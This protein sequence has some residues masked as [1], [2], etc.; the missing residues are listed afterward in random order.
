ME[1]I[2]CFEQN[3]LTCS[4]C[5]NSVCIECVISWMKEKAE[6]VCP[7]CN[8]SYELSWIYSKTSISQFVSFNNVLKECL[9]LKEQRHFEATKPFV[10]VYEKLT[11]ANSELFHL[12]SKMEFVKC[13]L[14]E[15]VHAKYPMYKHM[16][17]LTIMSLLKN[18]F[19]YLNNDIEK[20]NRIYYSGILPTDMQESCMKPII[21]CFKPNCKGVIHT[22]YYC[23]ICKL[24]I[25]IHCH[26]EMSA[27]HVC[28]N[29]L[30]ETVQNI[31]ETTKPCPTCFTRIMKTDGCDQMFCIDCKT[32]FSWDTGKIEKGRI[33]N[34]HYYQLVREGKIIPTQYE[35]TGREPQIRTVL[36]FQFARIYMHRQNVAFYEMIQLLEYFNHVYHEYLRCF[37]HNRM[38]Q[39]IENEEPFNL[40]YSTRVQYLQNFCT[41]EIFL[42]QCLY[43]FK[44]IRLSQ[45]VSRHFV[46]FMNQYKELLNYSNV[47]N[48]KLIHLLLSAEN[49]KYYKMIANFSFGENIISNFSFQ[50]LETELNTREDIENQIKNKFVE[51][52]IDNYIVSL[53]EMFMQILKTFENIEKS[54]ISNLMETENLIVFYKMNLNISAYFEKSIMKIDYHRINSNISLMVHALK[55]IGKNM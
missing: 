15:K 10:Q 25:C 38:I 34:P 8:A 47:L 9:Y 2:V 39:F 32:A 30:K 43:K 48:N 7:A 24:N 19:I 23:D 5:S 52:P 21:K 17:K 40:N 35:E 41:K 12:K 1:C 27:D 11:V 18:N 29:E 33:H 37:L 49:D 36:K 28:N 54:R 42:N 22:D 14:I 46:R 50:N 55:E 13:N 51:T 3:N 45:E 26:V 53:V 6:P 16:D 20:Y 31:M 4:N 44:N